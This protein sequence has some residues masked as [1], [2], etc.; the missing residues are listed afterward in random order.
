MERL[1][2]ARGGLAE[3]QRRST[4]SSS[5][6]RPRSRPQRDAALARDRRRGRAA[7][8]AQRA[9]A[10]VGPRRRPASTSTRSCADSRRLGAAVLRGRRCEGCRLELNPLDLRAHHGQ[11]PTDEV[12][13]CEECRRILVRTARV[14]PVTRRLVVEADGGSRGNPGPAGYGAL[15]RDARHRRG[16]RRARRV[17]RGSRRTTSPSTAG[18]IAGL[19]AARSSSTRRLPSRSGWTPSSSSSR[20]RGGGRS[21]TRTCAGSPPRPGRSSARRT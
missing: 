3:L 6:G 1:E 12:V 2:A 7:C 19:R 13:R 14:R 16:A 10:A 11:A 18:L 4:P 21:S 9:T 8:S 5:H 20:C 17:H 15:V